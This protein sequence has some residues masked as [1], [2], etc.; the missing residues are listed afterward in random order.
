MHLHP[1][2]PKPTRH[3]RD[4][5]SWRRSADS[6]VLLHV[7]CSSVVVKVACKHIIAP[8]MLDECVASLLDVSAGFIFAVCAYAVLLCA[9]CTDSALPFAVRQNAMRITNGQVVMEA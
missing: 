8:P 5:S 9:A 2:R 4:W 6:P 1:A 7:Q 3:R